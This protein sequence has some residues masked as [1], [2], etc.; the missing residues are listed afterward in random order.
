LKKNGW[1]E[2]FMHKLRR[3]SLEETPECVLWI[4][5][6][7]E[8]VYVNPASCRKLGYS[9]EE[10]YEMK[11]KDISPVFSK[12]K[13]KKM[14][15]NPSQQRRQVVETACITKDGGVI[16][17]KITIVF[18]EVENCKIAC[19]YG[20][21]ISEKVRAGAILDRR[22]KLEN[23][24]SG[25][26]STFI[27]CASDEIDDEINRSLKK[28]GQTEEVD[29]AYIFLIRSDGI[30]MDNTH[31]W[32]ARGVSPQIKN[33]QNCRCDAFPWWM[34]KLRRLETIRIDDVE[35]MPAAASATKKILKA[36]NIKSLVVV[37]LVTGA[38][39]HGFM[40]FDSVKEKKKWYDSLIT[41]LNIS[42][43]IIV[44]ALERKRAAS[45]I[46]NKIDDLQKVADMA[47]KMELEI[48]SLKSKIKKLE[49]K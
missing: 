31:E 14:F 30:L 49:T 3:Y 8:C 13:W 48:F 26:S 28:L 19:L 24:A 20:R 35:K 10:L 41:L 4:N 5:D 29:R 42:G 16:N 39:L 23:I 33:L 21:D 22:I 9:A 38:Y 25:M 7:A 17:V 45:L 11:F 12:D 6:K 44:N 2:S 40:G 47:V 43:E 36:Q 27:K 1:T 32:C 15:R 18:H 46:Q 37:P 34:K